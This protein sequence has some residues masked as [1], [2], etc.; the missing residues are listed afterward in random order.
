MSSNIV[1]NRSRVARMSSNIGA[2]SPRLAP[3]LWRTA[4]NDGLRKRNVVEETGRAGG[5]IEPVAET[6]AGNRP[7][8]SLQ[9]RA[10]PCSVWACPDEC[11]GECRCC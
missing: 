7:L 11:N 5:A 1:T 3:M 8:L 4:A 9:F 2:N 6:I 10:L